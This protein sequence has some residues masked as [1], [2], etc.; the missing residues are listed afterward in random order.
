MGLH[1]VAHHDGAV[2]IQ[3]RQQGR[4]HHNLVLFAP[5]VL[6]E[7]DQTQEQLQ[8]ELTALSRTANGSSPRGVVTTFGSIVLTW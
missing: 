6:Q 8:L 2:Q 7:Y 1:R 4:D 3:L 5:E